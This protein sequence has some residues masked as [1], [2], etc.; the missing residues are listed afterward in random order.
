MTNQI[1]IEKLAAEIAEF[2]TELGRLNQQ[3]ADLA[4]QRP[5]S[6]EGQTPSEIAK[7]AQ[8]A[9]MEDQKRRSELESINAA[10]AAMTQHLTQKQL[11]LTQA[12]RQQRREALTVEVE[13]AQAEMDKEAAAIA[14]LTGELRK[15]LFNLKALADQ[16]QPAYSDLQREFTDPGGRVESLFTA[17]FEG[18]PVLVRQGECQVLQGEK[19]DFF[20]AERRELNSN[21]QARRAERSLLFEQGRERRELESLIDARADLERTNAAKESELEDLKQKLQEARS[22]NFNTRKLEGAIARAEQVLSDLNKQIS[23]AETEIVTKQE[24]QNGTAA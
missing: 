10:I 8:V 16:A 2:E 21:L 12:Q 14:K 11:E 17:Q 18:L 9:S 23:N 4:S 24:V 1:Q 13:A 7:A 5:G 19:L 22:A 3:K 20:A 6:P 15:K